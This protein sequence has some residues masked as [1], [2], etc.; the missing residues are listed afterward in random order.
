MIKIINEGA[1]HKYDT[2]LVSIYKDRLRDT[3][4]TDEYADVLNDM[5]DD[6][7]MSDDS[8]QDVYD[9]GVE[10]GLIPVAD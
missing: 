2:V 1:T 8:C 7:G 3:N 6:K 10:K 4:G 5:F 9:W